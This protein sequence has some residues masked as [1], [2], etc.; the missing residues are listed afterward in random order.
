MGNFWHILAYIFTPLCHTKLN[1]GSYESSLQLQHFLIIS[2]NISD[3]LS[4]EIQYFLWKFIKM[5]KVMCKSQIF[6]ILEVSNGYLKI[7]YLVFKPLDCHLH[8]HSY[9]CAKFQVKMYNFWGG[10]S[11]APGHITL[12]AAKISPS[13]R[14]FWKIL[15]TPPGGMLVLTIQQVSEQNI[16]WSKLCDFSIFGI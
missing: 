9:M 5:V 14:N 12:T 6:A 8:H 7:F 10:Q 11:Y 3:G 16:K 13:R 4:I 1:K 2:L 15:S